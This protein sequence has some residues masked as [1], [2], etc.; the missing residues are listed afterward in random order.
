LNIDSKIKEEVN[1][2]D[3][4]WRIFW[5]HLW[6][7]IVDLLRKWRESEETERMQVQKTIHHSLLWEPVRYPCRGSSI[8]ESLNGSANA[9]WKK[10]WIM[11]RRM[12]SRCHEIHPVY[13]RRQIFPLIVFL[14][15]LNLHLSSVEWISA[16]SDSSL[17]QLAVLS[18]DL[19]PSTDY[20]W[21]NIN[22]WKNES[23]LLRGPGLHIVT[24]HWASAGPLNIFLKHFKDWPSYYGSSERYHS[25]LCFGMPSFGILLIF[26]WNSFGIACQISA[27]E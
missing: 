8:H 4:A 24:F 23:N 7:W 17:Y 21:K 1:E 13:N 26:F 6:R 2:G 3:T 20:E 5:N 25:M 15:E 9:Q 27:V 18:L 16:S 14:W 11:K 10:K 12:H 19:W 22:E